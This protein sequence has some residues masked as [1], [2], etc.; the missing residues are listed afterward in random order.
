MLNK[1]FSN[2][3]ARM[4]FVRFRDIR[5]FLVKVLNVSISF[6][7]IFTLAFV[8]IETINPEPAFAASWDCLDSSGRPIA[9]K[10]SMTVEI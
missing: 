7:M 5:P 1:L 10:L 6:M 8:T 9:F 4:R 2:A 3:Y